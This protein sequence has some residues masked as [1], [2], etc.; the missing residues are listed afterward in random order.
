LQQEAEV[1]AE[2]HAR[3]QEAL[4]CARR[5]LKA[6]EDELRVGNDKTEALE[7][8]VAGLVLVKSQMAA[9]AEEDAL[10]AAR[11]RG[12]LEEALRVAKEEVEEMRQHGGEVEEELERARERLDEVL[13]REASKVEELEAELSEVRALSETVQTDLN[14]AQGNQYSSRMTLEEE[15][16]ERARAQV[17][18]FFRFFRIVKDS[19]RCV[20]R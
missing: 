6:R 10:S 14:I 3:T 5:D 16:A 15:W 8:E 1:A 13:R 17:S 20:H 4:D 19:S 18:R 7:D 11:V 2:V 9:Q 12:Q